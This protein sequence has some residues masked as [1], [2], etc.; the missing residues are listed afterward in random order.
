MIAQLAMNPPSMK[1]PR[2]SAAAD[3]RERR[4]GRLFVRAFG[5]DGGQEAK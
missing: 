1:E 3:A 5:A 2:P 4:T